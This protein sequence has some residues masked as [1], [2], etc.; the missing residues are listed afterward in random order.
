MFNSGIEF[1]K[2]NISNITNEE[3]GK[4]TTYIP[5]NYKTGDFVVIKYV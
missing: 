4:V 3:R 5:H 1:S 2:N